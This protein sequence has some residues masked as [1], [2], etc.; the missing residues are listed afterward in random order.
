VRRNITA[1]WFFDFRFEDGSRFIS[2]RAVAGVLS[3]ATMFSKPFVR[4][5]PLLADILSQRE[6]SPNSSQSL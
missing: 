6:I 1:L 3:A 5:K 2:E 4:V